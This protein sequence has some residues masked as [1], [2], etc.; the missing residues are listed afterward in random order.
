MDDIK[1][2]GYTLNEVE[3]KIQEIARLGDVTLSFHCKYESMSKRNYD[4]NDLSSVLKEGKIKK[5]PEFDEK[6]SDWKFHV[7]G[8]TAEGDKATVVVVIKSHR[9]LICVTI[10]DK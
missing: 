9:E 5:N 6:H 7:E 4:M 1:Y 3:S 2:N 8:N 10:I